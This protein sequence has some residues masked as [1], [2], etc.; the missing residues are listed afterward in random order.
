[1]TAPALTSSVLS[2]LREHAPRVDTQGEFPIGSLTALRESGLLGLLVPRAYGGADGDLRTFVETAQELASACLSTASIWAMHCQQ[3]DAIARFG[4][5]E[6]RDDLMPSIARGETYIASVTTERAKG[7]HLL[8]AQQALTQQDG[9][10]H[11]ERQ[12]PVVT[13]GRHADGFLITMRAH[14]DARPDEVSLVY[15][16]RKQLDVRESGRWDAMGMRGTESLGLDLAGTVPATNVVGEP[17]RFRTVAVESM[18]PL[19]HLGWAACWLGAA[20]GCLR[21]LVAHLRRPGRSGGPD[22]TSD[23]FRE[24]LARIRLD[25]ELTHA[26][27]HRVCQEVSDRRERGKSLDRHAVQIHLNS[28]KLAASDLAFRAVDRMVELAGLSAGYAKDSGLSLERCF[29]DLRSA[30]LNYA[31]DRLWAVNGALVLVDRSVTL[32]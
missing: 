28:L 17:G 9:R 4:S 12:A 29:R 21:E 14:E 6:L 26:Y 13:G 30:S 15:A 7:G 24:R 27:L 5:R 1:M 3:V 18:I 22:L 16:Q 2:V 8:S 11:I 20:R 23:L 10:L 32:V 31:N 19:A 25:L